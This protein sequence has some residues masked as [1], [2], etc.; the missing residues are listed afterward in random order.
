MLLIKIR[1]YLKSIGIVAGA[2]LLTLVAVL[3]ADSWAG[4][5][6]YSL[7]RDSLYV[8]DAADDTVK[9]FDA[10]TGASQG[11]FVASGAGN[12]HGPRGLIFGDRG[13]LL[14]SNQNVGL[15]GN[16]SV[17]R[18][19]GSTGAFLGE[20]VSPTD[21]H[22][23]YS[24]QGIVLSQDRRF[25]FVTEQGDAPPFTPA[26]LPGTFKMFTAN[27]KFVADLDLSA[28]PPDNRH[29]RAVVVGPDRLLYVSN[30][31]ILGGIGGQILRFYQNGRFK[32]I[33]V[34]EPGGPG[35]FNRPQ[36]LVSGPNGNLYVTSFRDNS[37]PTASGN[38]D[39][40]R[41]YSGR[42][43]KFLGK[44]DLDNP[45]IDGT[46]AF[47]QALLF[48]PRGKLF[49]P[50]AG[51]GPSTGEVRRYDVRTGTYDVFVKASAQGGPLGS[52]WFL[53]FR[54]TD[55]ATLAY[56]DRD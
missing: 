25:L 38:T 19:D 12:L 9:R 21:P 48:G 1:T 53:T 31:P 35:G 28:L 16:G 18:F 24:P 54:K 36:G 55:P 14:V 34:T 33:F 3:G 30:T 56:I 4:N 45:P 29:P 51:N 13:N 46:R 47:A 41:I 26:I 23:P 6:D 8:G 20:L 50:I 32:D 15:S 10:S 37:Q 17:L 11:T 40:I 49:V 27:G 52:P 22:A 43:G 5:S 39:A 7:K 2:A 42:T 44:I